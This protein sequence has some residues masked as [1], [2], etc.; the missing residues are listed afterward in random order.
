MHED[1]LA[2]GASE[3][4]DRGHAG[5]AVALA[6]AGRAAI[7]VQGVEAPRTVVAMPPAELDRACVQAAMAATESFTGTAVDVRAARSPP[8]VCSK[9][10]AIF[11]GA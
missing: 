8:G 1:L 10:R 4:A 5:A 7:D 3:D 2:V 6:V 11:E 9:I